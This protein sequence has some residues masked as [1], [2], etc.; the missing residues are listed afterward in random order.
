MAT[1]DD[2]L[3]QGEDILAADALVGA[4]ENYKL[5]AFLRAIVSDAVTLAG[6]KQDAQGLAEGTRRA[7][8]TQVQDAYE[9]GNKLIREFN[10][11]ISNLNDNNDE[12][13]DTPAM[14]DNYGLGRVLPADLSHAYIKTTLARIQRVA[15]DVTPSFARP[16]AS[17]LARIGEILAILN[18]E[19]VKASV[20]NRASV[21][22]DKKAATDALEA[23]VSRVRF[24][25]WATLPLMFKD[26]LLH[27]YGFVPRQESAAEVEKAPTVAGG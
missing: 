14:R 7:A 23:A 1:F 26:A 12:Q 16:R 3:E 17:V 4:M 24:Y 8:S 19:G 18:T 27:N 11:F 13:I 10:R 25:L 15:P 20:G 6:G 21:T 22:T 9:S 5:P 2:L